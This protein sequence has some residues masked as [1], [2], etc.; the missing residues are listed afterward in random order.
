VD[1]AIWQRI[2]PL[3]VV[4]NGRLSE[5]ERLSYEP[6]LRRYDRADGA[7]ALISFIQDF[8][9]FLHFQPPSPLPPPRCR[10]YCVLDCESSSVWSPV[11][12]GNMFVN[13]L[14]GQG[15]C[16]RMINITKGEPVPDP[17][18]VIPTRVSQ[19]RIVIVMMGQNYLGLD[20]FV[21]WSVY[22]MSLVRLDCTAAASAVK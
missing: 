12:F 15:E 19:D 10:S 21:I 20:L 6:G 22:A 11:S 17:L 4:K 8:L 14:K 18:P 16:W 3:A 1:Y 7:D 2:W 13:R 5:V 9:H